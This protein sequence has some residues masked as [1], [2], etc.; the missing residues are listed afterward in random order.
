MPG[1]LSYSALWFILFVV[2]V[3]A[4]V[5]TAGPLIS[6]WFCIGAL[7]ALVAASAGTSF[8]V[9]VV[10]FLVISIALLFMTKP[11]VKKFVHKTIVETNADSILG[12][13]GIVTEE[14]NNLQAVG[15]VKVD[16]KIWTARTEDENIIITQGE[17][18]KILRIEG[19]K[20]IV[21]KFEK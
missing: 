7:A 1:F 12:H 4:E 10:V 6:I 18:V 2:F 16:G 19:V 3:I 9:Q 11:L 8:I 20:V 15:A 14:I 13:N 17:E 5:A 21:K